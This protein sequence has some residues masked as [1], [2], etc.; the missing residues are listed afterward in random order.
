MQFRSSDPTVL[1]LVVWRG[2]FFVSFAGTHTGERPYECQWCPKTF[3][4]SGDLTAHIRVR[5]LI[6]IWALDQIKKFI[7]YFRFTPAP[8][9]TIAICARKHSINRV[10]CVRIWDR[11]LASAPSCVF[12]A[13]EDSRSRAASSGTCSCTRTMSHQP[14]TPFSKIDLNFNEFDAWPT[15]A[16]LA[17]RGPF[18][19]FS[20]ININSSFRR[21]H[22]TNL[23]FSFLLFLL[24]EKF[25]WKQQFNAILEFELEQN[26]GQSG[27]SEKR[28]TVLNE[29]PYRTGQSVQ[30]FTHINYRET[31]EYQI[32]CT[33]LSLAH[34]F[35]VAVDG[36]GADNTHTLTIQRT[37]G[38]TVVFSHDAFGSSLFN[39]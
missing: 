26:K 25:P 6:S 12:C 7:R 3:A 2:T 20:I 27:S 13:I 5:E 35:A 15:M 36:W 11:I 1:V 9:P 39:Y 10:D 30:P 23:G 4:Q 34:R 18:Q 33:L 28:E 22:G 17:A 38:D 19:H 8:G 37:N 32:K 21:Y 31:R 24:F 14:I 16:R 29:R